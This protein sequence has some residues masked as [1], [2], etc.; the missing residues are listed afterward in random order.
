MD[1]QNTAPGPST[2]AA[3]ISAVLR[4]AREQGA[5]GAA[6]PTVCTGDVPLQMGS[7]L[8]LSLPMSMGVRFEVVMLPILP[9]LAPSGSR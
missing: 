8:W 3:P 5:V 2:A 6:A 7:R 1:Q 4:E 9:W